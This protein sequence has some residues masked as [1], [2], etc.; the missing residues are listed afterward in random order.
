MATPEVK[1]LLSSEHFSVDG[2]LLRAWASHSS[3]EPCCLLKVRGVAFECGVAGP[4]Q[5]DTTL[6]LF[7]G[8][9]YLGQVPRSQVQEEFRRADLFVLPTLADSF[10][11]AH[12]EAMACGVLVITTPHCG[13]VV[14]EGIDGFIVPIRDAHQV[15]AYRM[16]QLLEDRS[17]RTQ[18]GV[19]AHERAREFSWRR[20]DERLL[21]ALKVI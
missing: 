7:E 6:P 8:P 17:L 15:L 19:S 16:Q 14:C 12:L 2:T 5:V 21:A 10:G 11:L 13:S 1:L 18:M 9:S 4:P 3:L 20:Y